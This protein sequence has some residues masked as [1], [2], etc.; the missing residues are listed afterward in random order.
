MRGEDGNLRA[1]IGGCRAQTAANQTA[2]MSNVKI[3][4][5][6]LDFLPLPFDCLL[7]FIVET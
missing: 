3:R 7:V 5:Q 4:I 2:L 1:A 6:Y